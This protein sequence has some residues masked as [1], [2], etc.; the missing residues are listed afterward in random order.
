MF[1]IIYNTHKGTRLQLPSVQV[2]RTCVLVQCPIPTG[3]VDAR[4]IANRTVLM[5]TVPMCA[6]LLARI[7][8]TNLRRDEGVYC[9]VSMDTV[10][11]HPVPVLATGVVS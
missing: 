7:N 4:A 3:A 5:G 9:A 2:D 8:G 6:P 10:N 1:S 11:N